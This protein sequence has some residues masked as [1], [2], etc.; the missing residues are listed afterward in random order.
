MN[1]CLDFL[2]WDH[3]LEPNRRYQYIERE[4]RGGRRSR[5]IERKLEKRLHFG[6]SVLSCKNRS[7]QHIERGGRRVEKQRY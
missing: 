7:Y 1:A 3:L 6:F 4:E 2:F 5:D